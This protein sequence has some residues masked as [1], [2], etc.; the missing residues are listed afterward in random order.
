MGHR[1]KRMERCGSTRGEVARPGSGSTRGL[2]RNRRLRKL[3]WVVPLDLVNPHI[4]LE[5]TLKFVAEGATDFDEPLPNQ[6]KYRG[7]GVGP[8]G[9]PQGAM[10]RKWDCRFLRDTGTT[11]PFRLAG[12][13]PVSR[14]P[15]LQAD[16]NALAT[17]NAK[18]VRK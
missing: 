13:S 1:P 17:E 3:S 7:F 10:E 18:L 11:R 8:G 12:V 5:R 4:F 2:N 16:F 15:E 14:R 9:I 6:E